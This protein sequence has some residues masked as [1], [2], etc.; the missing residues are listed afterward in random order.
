MANRHKDTYSM[1]QDAKAGLYDD[2]D[3]SGQNGDYQYN[4]NYG[5][6]YDDYGDYGD[7]GEETGEVGGSGGQK[8]QGKSGFRKTNN[9]VDDPALAAEIDA[10]LAD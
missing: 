10:S 5:N 3:Y 2:D 6:E 1:F 9:E 8:G 4:N 7:Y